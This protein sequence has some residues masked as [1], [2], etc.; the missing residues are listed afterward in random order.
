MTDGDREFLLKLADLME[1]HKASFCYTTRDD[2]IHVE[3]DGCEVFIGWFFEDNAPQR[4]PNV[5]AER[6]ASPAYAVVASRP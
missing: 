4:K 6:P 3:L 2:G 1:S 5:V